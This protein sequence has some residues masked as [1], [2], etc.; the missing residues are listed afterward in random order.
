MAFYNYTASLSDSSLTTV[1]TVGTGKTEVIIGCNI[2]N[3]ST[4]SVNVDVKA[5]GV[6]IVKGA[7]VPA[8]SAL[9]VL[10]GKIIAEAADTVQVQSSSASGDCDVILSV[11][12]Q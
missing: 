9:S 2:A 1:H 3:T 10:D 4:S 12:E 7:P 5:A 6:Y 8:G 11:L